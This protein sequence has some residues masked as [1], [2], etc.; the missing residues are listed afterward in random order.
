MEIIGRCTLRSHPYYSH[1]KIVDED[2]TVV[3]AGWS[4]TIEAGTVSDGASIPWPFNKLLP[5]LHPNYLTAAIIH[6]AL[7]GQFN[8][9]MLAVVK[10]KRGIER[11]LTWKESA[12]WFRE[13]LKMNPNNSKVIRRVFYHAVMLKKRF[14][15]LF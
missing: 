7:T 15:N 14:K 2:F 1:L 6:D 13:A 10:N 11:T 12:V 3:K 8:Q 4:L 9:G 5:R